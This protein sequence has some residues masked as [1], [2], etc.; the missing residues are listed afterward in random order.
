MSLLEN[1]QC[2]K[3]V[4]STPCAPSPYKSSVLLRIKQVSREQVL[5]SPNTRRPSLKFLIEF[6]RNIK[7]PEIDDDIE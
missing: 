6:D 7:L 1:S 3:Y 5:L 2:L 4:T